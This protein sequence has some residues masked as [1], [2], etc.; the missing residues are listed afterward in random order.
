MINYGRQFID[1]LDKKAVLSI[2]KSNWLTQGPKIKHFE[3]SLKKSL[4]LMTAA[5]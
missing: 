5:W 2:L 1:N 3:N 4:M